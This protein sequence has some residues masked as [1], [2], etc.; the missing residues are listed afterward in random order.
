MGF[1]VGVNSKNP[2]NSGLFD[3]KVGFFSRK[4]PK[5]GVFTLPGVLFKSGAALKWIRYFPTLGNVM[6]VNKCFAYLNSEWIFSLWIRLIVRNVRQ[7]MEL[8]QELV[9]KVMAS[10]ALV[11]LRFFLLR[12]DNCF[13]HSLTKFYYIPKCL[14]NHIGNFF[15]IF[16]SLLDMWILIEAELYLYGPSRNNSSHNK[17]MYLHVQYNEMKHHFLTFS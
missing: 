13:I 10:A 7:L 5:T 17:S 14:F 15:N 11:R 6:W 4:I 1:W 8:H 3:Q 16:N 2:S 12:I 9:L